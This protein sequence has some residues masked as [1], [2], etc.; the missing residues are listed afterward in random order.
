MTARQT[1]DEIDEQVKRFD[2]AYGRAVAPFTDWVLEQ[3]ESPQGRTIRQIVNEGWEKFKVEQAIT[4]IVIAMSVDSAIIKVKSLDPEAIVNESLLQSRVRF[5]PW[6]SDGVNLDRRMKFAN[7]K[8]KQ[9]ITSN[10]KEDFKWAKDYD[11]NLKSLRSRVLQSGK[12]DEK[13]LRKSVRQITADIRKLGF[14]KDYTKALKDLEDEIALLSE[15]NY[16]TSDTKKAYQ[17][18]IRA[19]KGQNLEA[20]EDAVSDTIKKKS[21]YIARRVART[22]QAR[23]Q[24]D[25]FLEMT[26]DDKDLKFYKW[27]LDASHKITDECDLFAKADF[28]LGRGVFP[29]NKIPPIPSHPHCICFLTEYYPEE[30]VDSRKF[31]FVE[32]G[33]KFLKK[34][35][36]KTQNLVL[37]SSENGKAFREGG[38]WNARVKVMGEKPKVE[39]IESRF[40]GVVSSKFL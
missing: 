33:N 4:S 2:V 11:K 25:A 6:A 13:I 36:A 19:V 22:E 12:V 34:Q 40:K 27:N 5:E 10:I 37:K 7:T 23:S 38:D 28:G 20:F 1:N 21:R 35:N 14:T 16:P 39:S 24:L 32:G 18:F 26:K 9:L 17:G 15:M 3:L 8:T 29:K 31:S 30:D